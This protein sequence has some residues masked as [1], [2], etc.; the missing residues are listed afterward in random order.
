MT[1]TNGGEICS[2]DAIASK[3]LC[4]YCFDALINVFT[5]ET[6]EEPCFPQVFCPLFVSW[7]KRGPVNGNGQESGVRMRGCVG[8]LEARWLHSA[9]KDFALRSAFKDRRF[10][11]ISEDEVP[12]LICTVSLLRAF[13]PA[14]GVE[15]WIIGVNGLIIKFLDPLDQCYRSATYLPYVAQENMWNHYET[16]DQLIRKS[17][18][19]GY[20]SDE[21]RH[22]LEITVYECSVFSYSYDDY[23]QSRCHQIQPPVKP[24]GCI[25]NNQSTHNDIHTHTH[26]NE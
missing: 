15:D 13:R 18:F 7:N 14:K 19:N 26:E 21:L 8:T 1:S 16:V 17:G 10:N 11:P 4:E 24:N 2:E 12:F 20:I 25:I 9:L 3:E 6:M 23:L 5:G 22:S